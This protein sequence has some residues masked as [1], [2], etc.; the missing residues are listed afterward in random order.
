MSKK[1]VILNKKLS[2]ADKLG[3]LNKYGI[4][5][6]WLAGV[7]GYKSVGSFHSS[8]GK[9]VIMEGV[10]AVIELVEGNVDVRE[11]IKGVVRKELGI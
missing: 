3:K 1:A 9:K 4:D 5:S 8:R 7:F 2:P 11:V 6:E 10:L